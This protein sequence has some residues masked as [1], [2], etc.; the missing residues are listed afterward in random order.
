[1]QNETKPE[2]NMIAPE[3]TNE[4]LKQIIVDLFKEKQLEQGADAK[5]S[6]C[7]PDYCKYAWMWPTWHTPH[8]PLYPTNWA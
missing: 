5:F 1:M 3:P 4:E 2:E 6:R 7:H 8:V